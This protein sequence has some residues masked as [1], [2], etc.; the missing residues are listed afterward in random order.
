LLVLD[1]G[2]HTA[3][4]RSVLF[5]RDGGYVFTGSMDKSLRVW[6]AHTGKQ[7]REVTGLGA[8]LECVAYSGDGAQV[9]VGG[10]TAGKSGLL[11]VLDA[12]SGKEMLSLDGHEDVVT[13]VTFHLVKPRLVSV[14]RD[15]TIR[16]WEL[17][18]GRLLYRDKHREPILR[19]SLSPDGT[20]LGTATHEVIKL[21]DGNA[22]PP[23]GKEKPPGR[24][25]RAAGRG[26]SPRSR[27]VA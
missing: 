19:L 15:K 9:A 25:T 27:V 22:E 4:V 1:G 21:W 17:P 11:K 3:A 8:P 10:G 6:D 26:G 14:S 20:L 13:G 2:G 24:G 7:V 23:T 5:S 18:G 12:T 16:T